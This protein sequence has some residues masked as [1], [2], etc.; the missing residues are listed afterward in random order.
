[1]ISFFFISSFRHLAFVQHS[2]KL[3]DFS[4]KRVKNHECTNFKRDPMAEVFFRSYFVRLSKLQNMDL[5]GLL[6][7]SKCD[8]FLRATT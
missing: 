1:M 5:H 4:A 3:D 8:P 7:I 2:I 6:N